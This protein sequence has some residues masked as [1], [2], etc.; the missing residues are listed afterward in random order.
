[1]LLK[2]TLRLATTAMSLIPAIAYA[3]SSASSSSAAGGFKG[4]KL[5]EGING[6]NTLAPQAGL[7]TFFQYVALLYPW[8]LGTAAG[9]TL[10]YGLIGGVTIMMSGGDSGKE[11]EGKNKLRQAIMGLLLV[12]FSGVILNFLNPTFFR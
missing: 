4:I 8:V 5:L 10:L 11:E 3:Q 12:I 1:M 9:I 2:N 6:T 7:G